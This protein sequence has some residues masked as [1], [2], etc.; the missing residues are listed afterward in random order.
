MLFPQMECVWKTPPLSHGSVHC[1]LSAQSAS[2]APNW[3]RPFLTSSL[4]RGASSS[5]SKADRRSDPPE[6]NWKNVPCKKLRRGET[7][8]CSVSISG[9]WKRPLLTPDADAELAQA[10]K[11]P[12]LGPLA[13]QRNKVELCA[14]T[15]SL[16]VTPAALPSPK[17]SYACNGRSCDRIKS[18]LRRKSCC[19]RGCFNLFL[20]HE[21]QEVCDLWHSLNPEQQ[22]RYLCSQQ[23]LSKRTDWFLCGKEVAFPCLCSLL[24]VGQN[25]MKKKLRHELDMRK[26]WGSSRKRLERRQASDLVNLFFMELYHGSCE[27]LPENSMHF[28]GDDAFKAGKEVEAPVDI[29]GWTPEAAISE[30]AAHFLSPNPAVPMRHLPPGSP[31]SLFW[32]FKAWWAA[33]EEHHKNA[34]Q[35]NSHRVQRERPSWSTFWRAWSETWSRFL[36]FRKTSQHKDCNICFDFRVA[37]HKKNIPTAEKMKLAA[38]WQE[39]L[40]LQYHDRMLYWSLRFASRA[41]MNVLC[42]II[43][44]LDKCKTAYPQWV[45]HR[46][47]AYAQKPHRPRSVLTAVLCHGWCTCIYLAD[48][49][50]NHG[51]N[52][53]CELICRSLDKV[54]A[55]SRRTG[56]PMPQHLVIQADNTV[57]LCKNSL[58]LVFLSYLVARGKFSTATLNFLLEG[59][60]HEDVDRF[61]AF[62]LVMV[63]RRYRFEIPED[64]V[65]KMQEVLQDHV[66]NK[67]E[68]LYA[69]SVSFV[70]DF[71]AW[72]QP[73]GVTLYNA[74]MPRKNRPAAHAF[75]VKTRADLSP[76]EVRALG[77][78]RRRGFP[79]SPEDVFIITKGRMHMTEAK[80]PVLV[81]PHE[82]LASVR[83]TSPQGMLPR[84]PFD[85]SERKN[86]QNLVDLLERMPQSYPHALARI[87]RMMAGDFG[88]EPGPFR[89]L[90][91]LAPPWAVVQVTRN[92]YYE[93]LPDNSWNLLER[94]R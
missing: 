48:E 58:S 3:K 93:H 83:R 9:A 15:L 13:N 30:R 45:T 17:T 21:V 37:L 1:P 6:N 11:R 87:E 7:P 89:W 40:T 42:I 20:A 57:A 77:Q 68:D 32:Q 44:S 78:P 60:T 73:V 23:K 36:T 2:G 38:Q 59:H 75:S 81:L 50:I 71:E 70:R 14:A 35:D 90:Q 52:A 12:R 91:E 25:T 85:E 49:E 84:T 39:H 86:L 46:L 80:P 61:F 43:D 65:H 47:P 79:D 8:A 51:G 26:I 34:A 31:V 74:M 53:F 55:I 41:F 5:G 4:P 64:L 67:K 56:R 54:A 82:T 27:D 19:R 94:R 72:L 24:G 22:A 88:A 66:A 92:A 33:L 69:E 29:F 10:G 76:R 28:Q 63:L 16:L 18:M 62:I